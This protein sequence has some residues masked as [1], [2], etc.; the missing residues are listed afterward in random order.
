M[1]FAK[2]GLS[3]KVA[4]VPESSNHLLEIRAC[5]PAKHVA[6]TMFPHKPFSMLAFAVLAMLKPLLDSHSGFW[7]VQPGLN[8]T[9]R[10]VA[11]DAVRTSPK[12]LKTWSQVIH[13]SFAVEAIGQYDLYLGCTGA[14]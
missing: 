9:Y 13:E 6:Q 8:I 5:A 1:V 4:E 7:I 10:A 3:S 14:A 12:S 2:R 11:D